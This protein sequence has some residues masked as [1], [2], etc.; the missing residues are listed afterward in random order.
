MSIELGDCNL[1]KKFDFVKLRECVIQI[2]IFLAFGKIVAGV[3][4]LEEI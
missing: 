1:I 2:L 4:V 3:G